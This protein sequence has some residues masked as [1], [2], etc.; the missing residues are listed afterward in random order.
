MIHES[1]YDFLGK[2]ALCGKE[3]LYTFTC[4]VCG[5]TFCINHRLPESHGCVKTTTGSPFVDSPKINYSKI[6]NHFHNF[7]SESIPHKPTDDSTSEKKIKKTRLIMILLV[8]IIILGTLGGGYIGHGVGFQTGYLQGDK[9][10]YERG[11]TTGF[12]NGNETGYKNGY[13]TGNSDGY[14]IGYTTG[15]N[16]GY[17][18]GYG[19]GN[20]AGYNSGYSVG[21][22][23]G[24]S[25][26]NSSGFGVGY[27]IGFSKGW[28]TTGFNIRDPTYS[29]AINFI[30]V[31]KTDKNTYVEGSYVCHDFSYDVKRN[32]FKAGYRC[33]YIVI[34]FKS[35]LG[36]AIVGFNTTDKGLLFIEPQYDK[37]VR[38]V[39]GQHYSAPNGFVQ[40]IYDDTITKI[41]IVP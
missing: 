15:N 9:N 30:V 34:E 13:T 38:V 3:E 37:V 16:Y 4:S 41:E 19:Q 11:L 10:G 8:I 22:K 7:P 2:C 32:A 25:T 39:I 17:Q 18:N 33:F 14:K 26:G 36:H 23:S 1:R 6:E 24:Y 40:P 21:Y 20:T 31:D 35:N 5:K 27:N 12:K 29:E 28:K